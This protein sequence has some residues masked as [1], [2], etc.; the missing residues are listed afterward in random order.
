MKRHFNSPVI[1]VS[2][3]ECPRLAFDPS[4]LNTIHDLKD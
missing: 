1:T 2:A 4:E 3:T